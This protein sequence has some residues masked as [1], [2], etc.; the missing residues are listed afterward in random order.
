MSNNLYSVRVPRSAEDSEWLVAAKSSEAAAQ[1]YI[2][3]V[4]AEDLSVDAQELAEAGEL[5]VDLISIEDAGLARVIDWSS[6]EAI[7]R[8]V[9]PIVKSTL[10]LDGLEIFGVWTAHLEAEGLE[11]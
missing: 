10:S 3:G 9:K 1:L 8:Q 4:I 11:P 7:R 2:E 6:P 5:Y